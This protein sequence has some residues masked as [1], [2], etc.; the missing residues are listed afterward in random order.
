MARAVWSGAVAFGLVSIP[1]KLYSAVSKKS[2]KFNQIDSESMSRI[3]QKRFNGEG[4]EVPYEKI[5]KG[6]EVEKDSYVIISE[7]EIA[8]VAPKASRMI[9]IA[10]FVSQAEIDPMLYDS[11]YF[12]IPEELARKPYSLLL[13][14]LEA[15]N[16]VAVAKVVMRSKEHLVCLRPRDGALVLS[17]MVYPVSYTHLTLPTICSV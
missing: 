11:A 6:Y 2:V 1:V 5:V 14:A 7:E 16:K 12:L 10:G 17:T 9:D 3:K 13:E 4:E 15:A 8:S